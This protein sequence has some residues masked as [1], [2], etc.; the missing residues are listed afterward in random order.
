MTV[1]SM[2]S[3][4][5]IVFSGRK[6]LSVIYYAGDMMGESQ[7]ELRKESR[8]QLPYQ[9]GDRT[10][11]EHKN[12]YSGNGEEFEPFAGELVY[13]IFGVTNDES[14]E[15]NVLPGGENWS[16]ILTIDRYIYDGKEISN[17]LMPGTVNNVHAIDWKTDER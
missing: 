1:E 13:G 15:N 12:F 4:G 5:E 8:H 9:D 11:F 14:N 17:G 16:G 10:L 6:T 7:F 2:S 3:N